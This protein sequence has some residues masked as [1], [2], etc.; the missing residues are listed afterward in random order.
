[1]WA[2]LPLP[3]VFHATSDKQAARNQV[4]G[5]LTRHDFRVDSTIL[6]KAKAQPQGH[7]DELRFYKYAWYFHM[8]RIA[9]LL[10][11]R[12]DELMVVAA[13]IVTKGKH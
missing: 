8:R 1:M 2:G 4:Y 9:P 13:S 12:G 5:V 7:P 11:A 3:G 6:E 10:V